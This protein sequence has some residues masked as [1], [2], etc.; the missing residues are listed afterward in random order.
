[1]S[2]AAKWLADVGTQAPQCECV[3]INICMQSLLFPF[4]LRP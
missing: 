3:N 1:M 4:Y 2:I